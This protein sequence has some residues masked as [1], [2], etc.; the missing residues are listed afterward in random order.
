MKEGKDQDMIP[1]QGG[2]TKN[3]EGDQRRGNNEPEMCQQEHDTNSVESLG[4]VPKS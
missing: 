1:S 2:L 3:D 4:K